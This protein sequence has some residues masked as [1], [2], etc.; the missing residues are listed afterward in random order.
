[1]I[2]EETMFDP[3]ESLSVTQ[4]GDR[5]YAKAQQDGVETVWERHAAQQPQVLEI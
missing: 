2:K 5:L 1:M 4:D 3:K